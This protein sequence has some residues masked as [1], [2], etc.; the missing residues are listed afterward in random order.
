MFLQERISMPETSSPTGFSV[1]QWTNGSG[2]EA[3][4]FGNGVSRR[5]TTDDDISVRDINDIRRVIEALMI[6]THS[7]QDVVG[8]GC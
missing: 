1:P 2:Q 8:G 4:P 7:H 6:H 5:V 3:L